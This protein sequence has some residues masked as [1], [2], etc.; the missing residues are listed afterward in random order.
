MSE[1]DSH[2]PGSGE[3]GRPAESLRQHVSARVPENV[4][5]GIFSTGAVVLTGSTEIVL[6]FFQTLGHPSQVAAR[7]VLPMPVLPQLIDALGKNVELYQKQFGEIPEV[8]GAAPPRQLTMQEIY[9][10]L[11]IPDERLSGSYANGVMI[12]HNATDFKFDFLTNL[13]PQP[14]VSSRIFLS[15]PQVPRLLKSLQQHL[16]QMKLRQQGGKPPPAPEEEDPDPD[17]QES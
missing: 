16:E 1:S 17:P 11:K 3:S 10:E 8:P 12:M 5:Q 2:D 4:S 6:D 7:V 14:A 15:A 9:D 13:Y